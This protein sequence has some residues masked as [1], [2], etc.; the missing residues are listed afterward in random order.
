[1]DPIGPWTVDTLTIRKE[2]RQ[3]RGPCWTPL[4]IFT[5]PIR[6]NAIQLECQG[7]IAMNSI[8]LDNHFNI[9]SEKEQPG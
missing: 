1:M 9:M 4:A 8:G 7:P 6:G 5:V 2:A 3:I